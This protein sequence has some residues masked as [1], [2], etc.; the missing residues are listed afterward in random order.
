MSNTFGKN[1]KTL[2]EKQGLTQS[3]LALR[4]RVSSSTIGMYEQGRRQPDNK[5]LYKICSELNV[6]TDYLLGISQTGEVPAREVNDVIDE[7]TQMLEAQESLMFKGT[8]FTLEDRKRVANAIQIA[9]AVVIKDFEN[10]RK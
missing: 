2:R 7:F 5:M 9:T 10:D 6:S 4:L 1:L 8:P 3:E